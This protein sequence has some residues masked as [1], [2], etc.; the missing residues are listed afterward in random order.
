[1]SKKLTEAKK[2]KRKY[3]RKCFYYME[4]DGS[5]VYEAIDI[6]TGA[7]RKKYF[8]TDDE[9][10]AELVIWLNESD[11][12]PLFQLACTGNLPETFLLAEEETEDPRILKRIEFMKEFSDDQVNLIYDLFGNL[13]ML[14]ERAEEA[15]KPDGTHPTEQTIYGREQKILQRLRKVLDKSAQQ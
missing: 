6:D 14:R 9:S 10:S 3:G 2:H 12:D 11:E 1:M 15:I 7:V 8:I 5:Y 13:K 4:E